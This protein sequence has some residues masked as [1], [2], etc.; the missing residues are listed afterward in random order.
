MIALS[1]S[2]KLIQRRRILAL[3]GSW[4]SEEISVEL[5]TKIYEVLS[6]FVQPARDHD[7][8]TRLTAARSLGNFDTWGF[9]ESALLP[10]YG[11]IVNS[12]MQLIQEVHAVESRIRLMNILGLLI[13]RMGAAVSFRFFIR[14]SRLA[15]HC[16]E[17]LDHALRSTSVEHVADIM[18]RSG[19]AAAV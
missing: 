2:L 11:P 10:Y 17:H 19:R 8:A 7:L 15:S 12:M 5:K 9:E 6:F 16:F 1:C 18:G 4:V 14:G 3:L 13:E